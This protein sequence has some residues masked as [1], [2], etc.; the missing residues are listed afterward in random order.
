MAALVAAGEMVFALPFVVAR[1]FRPTLLDVFGLTNLQLGTAFSV[2]G[3]VAMASYFPGGPLADRFSARR[4][5]TAALVATSLGGG[6]FATIPSIGALTALYAFWGLTTILLFW[7]ALL[8]ATREWGGEAA[9]GRAY[10]ILDGGRGLAAAFLASTMV[11]IF[12]AL[13]PSEAA[14]ATLAQRTYALSSVIWIFTGLTLASAVLVWIAVPSASPSV[15]PWG[16]RIFNWSGVRQVLAM[17]A[18]WRQAV[19]VVCAYVGYKA[20]DDFSLYAR[21][22]FDYND[23]AAAQLGT[24]SFW[25]RPLAAV[26][27]GYLAD[28]TR[29]SRVAAW[30]FSGLALGCVLMILQPGIHGVLVATVAATSVGIY[31]VRSVYFALLGEA[32]VP[33]AVTGSA[34]GLVSVIGF[35]PDVF[36][37]PVMGYLLDRSPGA[38]GH[39]H[40]FLFVAGFAVVGLLATLSFQ[41][42]AKTS[43]MRHG[44]VMSPR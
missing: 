37:G 12:A 23:V 38:L 20:T 2:Y 27:A 30:S 36:M 4:L 24:I 9:I 31:A 43:P 13:L 35:T 10:G 3:V 41:R 5:M 28:K 7:A 34:I 39:Q 40:V 22:A 11:L 21:D 15:S 29:P 1:V 32:R 8:R 26:G 6:I 44:D 33:L 14:S 17:P 18:V 25:V 42:F 19:I 16:S